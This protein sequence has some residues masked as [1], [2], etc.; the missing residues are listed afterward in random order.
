MYF[1]IRLGSKSAVF[2]NFDFSATNFLFCWC[3]MRRIRQLLCVE[4]KNKLR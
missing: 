2:K 1:M 4:I 3:E